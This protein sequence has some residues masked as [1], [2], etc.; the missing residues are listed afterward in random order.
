MQNKIIE[1]IQK[2]LKQ[3]NLTQSILAKHLGCT[4]TA[5]SNLL[6]E[7]SRLTIDDLSKIS[8]LIEV[9]VTDLI[10]EASLIS[11]GPNRF[12][13][14]KEVH[15]TKDRLNFFLFNILKKPHTM[16]NITSYT[17]SEEIKLLIM[18]R[19]HDLV[20][21]GVVNKTIFET[22]QN[23]YENQP[24][25]FHYTLNDEYS[26]RIVEI[27]K[28]LREPVKHIVST[29]ENELEAWKEK[30][31]DA[32]YLDFFTEDQIINQNKLLRQFLDLVKHQIRIN[33]QCSE[34]E[35][36]QFRAIFTSSCPYPID[37]FLN[38]DL[39]I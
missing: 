11:D 31:I 19:I 27:Y 37:Q 9:S 10:K 15:F 24:Q 30:N 26:D 38:K 6:N 16:A 28:M 21:S 14:K 35:K 33:N 4:Q 20:Q 18:E 29:S 17:Q 32:F 36:L 7:K 3:K 23:A 5:V 1:T 39:L 22:Y 25:I 13:S 2:I 8:E 34:K 12:P